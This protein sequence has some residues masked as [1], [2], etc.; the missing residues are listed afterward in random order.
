MVAYYN[1]EKVLADRT[2]LYTHTDTRKHPHVNR[3]VVVAV[4]LVLSCFSKPLPGH[5]KQVRIIVL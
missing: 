1:D 5:T 2:N 3:Y 4:A